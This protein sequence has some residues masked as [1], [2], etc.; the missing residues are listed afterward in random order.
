MALEITNSFEF[1]A[2]IHSVALSKGYL[3]AGDVEGSV[4][5]WRNTDENPTFL[6]HSNSDVQ[7]L[8][9]GV[10]SEFKFCSASKDCI[11]LWNVQVATKGS[12]EGVVIGENVGNV[13]NFVKFNNEDDLLCVGVD[14][15]ILLYHV[16]E[17]KVILQLEGHNAPVSDAFFL[18]HL[19]NCLLTI[20]DDRT[21]KIWNIAEKKI[22]YK[23]AILSIYPIVA[24]CEIKHLNRFIIGFSNGL[25]QVYETNTDKVGLWVKQISEFN[26]SKK[27]KRFEKNDCEKEIPQ[28]EIISS[29]PVWKQ[30]HDFLQKQFSK[31]TEG[32][33]EEREITFSII[34]LHPFIKNEKDYLMVVTRENIIDINLSSFEIE[35]IY[36]L[37]DIGLNNDILLTCS[38]LSIDDS[39]TRII[40]ATNFQPML[41]V[42]EVHH[43]GI[44]FE[45]I[46][47]N[48][49]DSTVKEDIQELSI[50]HHSDLPLHLKST[51]TKS[52]SQ[53]KKKTKIKD[54][55]VTFHTRIKSS[56]YSTE[57]PF[58]LKK[59]SSTP[60]KTGTT[61]KKTMQSSEAIVKIPNGAPSILD[62][63]AVIHNSPIL[64]LS[65]SNDNSKVASG[66]NTGTVVISKYPFKSKDVTLAKHQNS[67]TGM[68]W[69]LDNKYLLT[70]SS[71]G[72]AILWN[73]NKGDPLITFKSIQSNVTKINSTSTKPLTPSKRDTSLQFKSSIENIS[74]NNM[75]KFI[76]LSNSNNLYIYKYYIHNT[77]EDDKLLKKNSEPHKYKLAQKYESKSQKITAVACPNKFL[78]NY[79]LFGGS[80]KNLEI[81]DISKDKIVRTFENAHERPIH[82]ITLNNSPLSTSDS[83]NMFLTSSIDGCIKLWDF[84]QPSFVRRYSQHKNSV[85]S[86]GNDFSPCLRHIATGSEDRSIYI[87]DL[88]QSEKCIQKIQAAHSDVVS[89]VKYQSMTTLLSCSFDYKL[90][91]FV[92][93]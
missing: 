74:F 48:N 24:V 92:C 39:N 10:K 45:E 68:G 50:S 8:A 61:F 4:I 73:T 79:I 57:K 16:T 85:Q 87:Y 21:F 59:K 71:D 81:Y 23:S 88:T 41:Y 28:F 80:N 62:K 60:I 11:K 58:M 55:P 32:G 7:A 76:V 35:K 27:V 17:G 46:T 84:R 93:P 53:T 77:K 18:E 70:S 66:S 78:S 44:N 37:E 9:F 14:N 38:C 67:I 2:A 19:S 36:S 30:Q 1:D 52:S 63:E 43:Q 86:I 31:T 51:M 5:I 82:T 34:D 13:I 75:D 29:E 3:A 40:A 42:F 72:S 54:L 47:K 83:I 22:V 20:S 89:D 90:K 26:I 15:M 65:I 12:N 69:S 91:T 56:G 25:I 49:T 33:D 6:N 64:R